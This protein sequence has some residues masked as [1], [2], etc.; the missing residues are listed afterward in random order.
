MQRW[1]GD[2]QTNKIMGEM[3]ATLLKYWKSNKEEFKD[4]V[5]KGE[6]EAFINQTSHILRKFEFSRPDGDRESGQ[7]ILDE[8]ELKS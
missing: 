4:A 2:I 7:E 6:A 3:W 8:N 1:V 5:Q